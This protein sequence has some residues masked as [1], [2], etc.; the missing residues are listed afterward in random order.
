MAPIHTLR[1]RL[2]AQDGG[3]II[4]FA[5]TLPALFGLLFCF[6]EMC[7]AFYTYDM[8]SESAREGARYAMVHG[9]S[10]PTSGNPT[11]EATATQVNTYVSGLGWPNIAGGTMTVSTTYPNGNEAVGSAVQVR[12]SYAFKITLAFVPKS[13]LNM[14][15]T[16]LMYIIQ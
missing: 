12:V 2:R 16:S 5:L 11:C 14:S 7:L 6:M 3:S 1:S 4:E 13:T 15:S 8:I 9:A 10:C